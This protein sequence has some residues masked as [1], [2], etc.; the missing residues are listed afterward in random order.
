MHMAA[1]SGK[2]V[3]LGSAACRRCVSAMLFLTIVASLLVA[4]FDQAVLM[5]NGYLASVYTGSTL[6]SFRE[7]TRSFDWDDDSWQPMADALALLRS[8]ERDRLYEKVF[9]EDKTKFQYAPT[10]L[11]YF[12]GLDAM[13]LAT[14]NR[15]NAINA[16]I[17]IL[18]CAA[19]GYLMLRLSLPPVARSPDA[20]VWSIVLPSF[21][22]A[23]LYYPSV[24]A[25]ELGQLQVWINTLF[26]FACIA[27]LRDAKAIAGVL[28]A[29]AATLK[30]Q[31]GIFL[32]WALLWREWRFLVGFLGAGLPIGIISLLIFGLHNHLAYLQ[33]LSFISQH[34]ESFYANN[35]INGL[36]HRAFQNGENLVFDKN[37]FAPFH[38][39]VATATFVSSLVF[40]T[41]ALLPAVFARGRRPG[42]IDL[43]IATI[44][45]TIASPIAWEHHYGIMLPILGIALVQVCATARRASIL[46]WLALAWILSGNYFPVTNYASDTW[47]NIVQS[48]LFFAALILLGLL[49]HL[50]RQI[51]RGACPEPGRDSAMAAGQA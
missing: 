25:L 37:A 29:L 11:V 18:G 9:F 8:P 32:I 43:G 46:A 44:C 40:L 20:A 10:S 33:V 31:F 34:G 1:A 51:A 30:P 12:V 27:W 22:T 26:V 24:R 50:R 7:M 5:R 48:Y 19:F 14:A 41:M 3:G 21:L 42:I 49:F 36:L 6:R 23:L 2:N 13:S 4:A 35:T 39:S 38:A 16:F 17:F 28:L 47:L 15:L 45:A